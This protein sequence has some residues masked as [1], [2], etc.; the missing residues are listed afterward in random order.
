V[1][2][3]DERVRV[4]VERDGGGA[5]VCVVGPVD[6][7]SASTVVRSLDS[8]KRT[9]KKQLV[10]LDLSGVT[11][12]DGPGAVA[13]GAVCGRIRRA[14]RNVKLV[15][16]SPEAH[17]ALSA[18]PGGDAVDPTRAAR[19]GGLETLGRG[20]TDFLAEAGK[21]ARLIFEVFARGVFDP[22][23][24]RFPSVALTA[25]EAVRIGVD[26]LPIV[27]LIGLLL[28]LITGFQAAHQLR[29]FGANI[30]VAN[31]VGLGMVRE[32]GPLMTAIILAG[33]SGSSIAAELGTMT[34]REEI[35]AL[36]TMGIDPVRYLVVPKVYAITVTGPALA[37]FSMAAGVLGGF[38]I[39]VTFLDLAP[40]AYWAQTQHALD[41][42]D[43]LH[44]LAKSLVFSWIVVLVSTYRGMNIKGGA[45]GV[46][47]ATTSS[48]VA[49]IFLII[50]TDSI[51][52]TASTVLGR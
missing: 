1:K 31:L 52:T 43:L 3:G 14:G 17:G 27:A 11:A 39:A 36:R 21:L 10:A 20:A 18:L 47:M 16:F 29:Q 50:V 40:G 2:K 32:L 23:R 26:A 28:G 33:R 4:D 25:R 30:Y 34:V 9:S 49:S 38:F 13:I 48:V 46:G 24:G 7:R 5:R 19:V 6:R 45:V 41:I 35:D 15:A 12:M 22:F 37:L 44:G 42:G 8:L 51:F